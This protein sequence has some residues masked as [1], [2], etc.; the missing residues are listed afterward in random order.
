MYF[1]VQKLKILHTYREFCI[2]KCLNLQRLLFYS[3]SFTFKGIISHFYPTMKPNVNFRTSGVQ[4][5]G[6]LSH[7]LFIETVKD[8]LLFVLHVG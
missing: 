7:I 2:K 3:Y 6:P 8:S 5:G 1:K 4:Q